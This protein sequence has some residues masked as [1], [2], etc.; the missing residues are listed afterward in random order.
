MAKQR[1]KIPDYFLIFVFVIT[2]VST[3]QYV[4]LRNEIKHLFTNNG[5]PSSSLSIPFTSVFQTTFEV[6]I[7]PNIKNVEVLNDVHLITTAKIPFFS[8]PFSE[9]GLVFLQESVVKE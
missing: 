2:L 9:T 5:I 3:L 1:L 6:K 8:I 4:I 7:T